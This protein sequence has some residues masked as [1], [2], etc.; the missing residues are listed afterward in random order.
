MQV[1][2]AKQNMKQRHTFW[3]KRKDEGTRGKWRPAKR[4]RVSTK[5][6]VVNLDNQA[7]LVVVVV[8]VV[9][10]VVVWMCRCSRIS[11]SSSSRSTSFYVSL[12]R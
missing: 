1:S 5:A 7:P 6:W 4:Y 3:V 10:V 8:V 12:H 9:E 11:S 2:V